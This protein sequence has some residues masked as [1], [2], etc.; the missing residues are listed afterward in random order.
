MNIYYFMGLFVESEDLINFEKAFP[1]SCFSGGL[2]Q[3]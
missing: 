1:V 2:T 3:M